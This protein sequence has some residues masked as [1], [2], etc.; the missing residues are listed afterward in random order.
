MSRM[1]DVIEQTTATEHV[2]ATLQRRTAH[3]ND[4]CRVELLEGC[5]PPQW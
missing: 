2:L 3:D 4:E 1:N 5:P